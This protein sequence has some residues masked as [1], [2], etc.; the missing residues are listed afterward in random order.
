RS[1][2]KVEAVRLL[3]R[4]PRT[5]NTGTGSRLPF[6]STGWRS[7]KAMPADASSAVSGPTSTSPP[8]AAFSRR[9]AT[10]TASPI[11]VTSPSRPTAV[12]MTSPL[13]MP[14][15]NARSPPSSRMARA[16]ATARSA[17]SSWATG[18]PNTAM[19]ASPR[20]LSTVPP[21]FSTTSAMRRKA[22][23]TVRATASGSVFSD[24][25]VKP[26]TSANR[27]VASLRSP[28]D[29]TGVGAVVAASM[30]RRVPHWPQKCWPA[31]LTNPHDGHPGPLSAVPQD[32]QKRNPAGLS[33]P[34]LPQTAIRTCLDPAAA[35]SGGGLLQGHEVAAVLA[36]GAFDGLAGLLARAVELAAKQLQLFLHLHHQL[37]AGQ[38]QPRGGEVLDALELF[39]VAIAVPPAAAAGAGGVEQAT[40]LVDAQRLRVHTCEFRGD[41]DHV[42]ALLGSVRGHVTPPSALSA[43]P[44]STRPVS[45]QPRVARL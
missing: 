25:D 19:S 18:T 21:W 23:S 20:Y 11:T 13:L 40:A 34:Q 28:G 42:D 30:L 41:G 29:E 6:R 31:G 12:A 16:A 43:I 15:E 24:S 36:V 44:L 17:S 38:V 45:Q 1:R 3:S 10:L 27:I 22:A 26:T 2:S 32:P 35:V 5:S 39:D 14:M 4:R 33:A 9:A 37:H 8:D 7:R